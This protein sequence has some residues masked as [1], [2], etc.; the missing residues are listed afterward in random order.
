MDTHQFHEK[1]FP[2]SRNGDGHE[3]PPSCEE[4]KQKL[5]E[6]QKCE[7][8]FKKAMA[9]ISTT[10][11]FKNFND[12][13]FQELRKILDSL[14]RDVDFHMGERISLDAPEGDK[15]QYSFLEIGDILFK[16]LDKKAGDHVLKNF[17]ISI[18]KH[19]W[20]SGLVQIFLGVLE[21]EERYWEEKFEAIKV[22][23]T[24]LEEKEEIFDKATPGIVAFL[25]EVKKLL[26]IFHR[27]TLLEHAIDRQLRLKKALLNWDEENNRK[28]NQK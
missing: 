24:T 12:T 7:N 9:E 3:R 17:G 20:V 10:V 19:I 11:S 25:K 13:D 15:P 27:W 28:R 21:R 5:Q 26:K 14:Y 16:W 1:N 6:L 18:S 23:V 4:Q 2:F 8:L 22:K